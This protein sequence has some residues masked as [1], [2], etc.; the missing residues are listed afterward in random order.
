MKKLVSIILV[1]MVTSLTIVGATD[2]DVN[3]QSGFPIVLNG[4]ATDCNSVIYNDTH[5]VPMRKVFEK[6]SA[7]VFYRMRDSQVLALTRD[8]DIIRHIVGS[9]DIIVNG[10]QKTFATPSVLINSET[11]IPVNMVSAAFVSDGI[12]CDNQQINIQRH[13]PDTE[14][15]KL[16]QD[17]LDLS[18]LGNFYPE[19]FQRYINYHTKMSAYNI[20]DVII[21]VNMDL[22]FPFYEN[23]TTIENPYDFSVLVNK[24]NQ[25]PAGFVQN[26]LV[27]VNREHT[28]KDGKE[29]LLEKTAYEKYIEMSTAASQ[30]GLSMKIASAYRTEDYQRGLYNKRAKSRGVANAD[31]Y[32]AR[33]GFSEH[34]TGLAIDINS[35][36]TSFEYSAEF[37]WLQKHA[38]EY[39]YILRY[40]KGKEWITG[41][42][43]EPWHYRYV[44]CD[45]AKI[46]YEEG[47]TYEEFCAKYV[48]S[49]F[50]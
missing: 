34:Q 33:A 23:V 9:H 43:Y 3:F 32:T 29:Y 30:E 50:R 38:H 41:Y 11:Y 16:V 18:W 40:Q 22:D 17:V 27:N 39:G 4:Q 6:M 36:K 47:I 5:Y 35:T 45:V 1:F 7:T 19:K 44:G 2:Q 21:L 24:H 15:H 46:I 20:H 28:I 48:S 12:F 14:Y 31:K 37:K 8:G 25:L 26:N 13:T 10:E 42:S 49:E